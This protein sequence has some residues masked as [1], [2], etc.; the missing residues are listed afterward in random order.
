MLDGRKWKAVPIVL[1][2]SGMATTF[3]GDELH[4]LT[5]DHDASL[6]EALPEF[7]PTAKAIERVV[8]N[9]RQ[10]LLAEFS[11]LGFIV[12]IQHGRYRVGPALQST[13]QL[14]GSLYYGRGDRRELTGRYYTVDRDLCGIQ[15][16]VEVFENLINHPETSEDQLQKFFEHHPHFL[17]D[18][19]HTIPLPH[20]RLEH[21]T[22]PLYIPDFILKP[23]V[24]Y[25][26][27][28]NWRV[29]DLKKPSAR[30]LAGPASHVRLSYDVTQA[31]AQLRDYRD[32]FQN[33]EN[34]E[35]VHQALGHRLRY[36]ELAVLIG[37]LRE[38]EQELLDKAQ[39]READVRIVTYDEVLQRQQ[40]LLA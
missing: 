4:R 1:V 32:Y 5:T 34:N 12:T 39:S 40:D 3:F 25:Q 10:H 24:A 28:T 8:H 31:I 35:R 13:E 30:L 38:A 16:E 36:P 9:Y 33:P 11:N 26:R 20:V 27:D 7:H 37:R 22:N 23:I 2:A 19:Q 21:P 15:H 18:L 6:L 29:L 17:G 14:E